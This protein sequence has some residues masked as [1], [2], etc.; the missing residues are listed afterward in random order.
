[1]ALADQRVAA[2]AGPA[3]EQP[4]KQIARTPRPFRPDG[5]REA[6]GFA[7]R[8]LTFL[9]VPPEVVADDPQ[10]WNIF[11]DPFFRR[12]GPRLPA[13]RLGVLDEPL[14]GPHELADIEFVVQNSGAAPPVAID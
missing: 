1:M 2:A 10:T 13:D 8:G 7:G 9:H 14:P 3:G 11:D 6:D 4:G 5:E 12:I